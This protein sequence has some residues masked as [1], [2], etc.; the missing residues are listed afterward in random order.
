MEDCVKFILSS[1]AHKAQDPIVDN[2]LREMAEISS[3][4]S[5]LEELVA[6]WLRPGRLLTVALN[7][8]MPFPCVS[9]GFELSRTVLGLATVRLRELL[10]HYPEYE[11]LN[12]TILTFCDQDG[13]RADEEWFVMRNERLAVR[14]DECL[15]CNIAPPEVFAELVLS[16]ALSSQGIARLSYSD[17]TKQMNSANIGDAIHIQLLYFAD[18][19]SKGWSEEHLVCVRSLRS[20]IKEC[21]AGEQDCGR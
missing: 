21:R 2:A 19:F 11:P 15:E 10:G 5:S 7:R 9:I 18:G 6:S 1:F 14:F 17:Q 20:F 8:E 12:E 16:Y 3:G 4:A 13:F